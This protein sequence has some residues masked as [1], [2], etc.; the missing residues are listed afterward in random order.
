MSFDLDTDNNI[1]KKKLYIY[2]NLDVTGNVVV[3]SDR[4]K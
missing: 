4:V 1:N 2:I 3:Y